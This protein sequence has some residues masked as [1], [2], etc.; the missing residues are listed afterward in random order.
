MICT[1]GSFLRI[2]ICLIVLFK[3]FLWNLFV[4][5]WYEP[6]RCTALCVLRVIVVFWLVILVFLSGFT[7]LSLPFLRWGMYTSVNIRDHFCCIIKPCSVITF[8]PLWA[9]KR[10]FGEIADEHS[11]L[12]AHDYGQSTYLLACASGLMPCFTYCWRGIAQFLSGFFFLCLW[13]HLSRKCIGGKF[14]VVHFFTVVM[15]GTKGFVI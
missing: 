3:G 8:W 6:G 12:Q 1:L 15:R 14:S 7:P 9:S 13:K 4:P 5:F 2:L 10:D 11:M